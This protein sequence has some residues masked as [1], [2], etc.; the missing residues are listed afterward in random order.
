MRGPDIYVS[1]RGSGWNFGPA[2]AVTEL[3]ST[4]GDIQ[5]SVRKDGREVVFASA[6]WAART[7]GSS[8]AGTSTI[9]SRL[10]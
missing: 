5:P 9:P 2:Q 8:P 7:S 4:S 3:N 1:E 10:P 6:R